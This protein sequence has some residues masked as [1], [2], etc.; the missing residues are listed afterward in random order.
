MNVRF[1]QTGVYDVVEY[2]NEDDETV[3]RSQW[4]SE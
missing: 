3:V 1:A 4:R 2:R